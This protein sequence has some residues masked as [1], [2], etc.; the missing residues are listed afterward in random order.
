MSVLELLNIPPVA[1]FHFVVNFLGVG[2]PDIDMRFQEVS[3]I[4][5]DLETTELK[6]GGE[7]R[8]VHKLPVRAKFPNLVLKRAA[9]PVPSMVLEWAK[10]AIY[11]FDFRPVDVQVFLLN[12]MHLPVKGWNFVSAYPVK[13]QT[14][15]LN[16]KNNELVI[17]TL[18]LAYKYARQIFF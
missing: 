7:N 5:A 12:D 18:E 10:D 9:Y 13:L 14:S 11:N 16:A 6:E 17:Q 3:G 4:S 8:F 2:L 15:N 1:G